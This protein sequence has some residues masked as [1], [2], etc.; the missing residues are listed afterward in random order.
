MSVRGTR[1]TVPAEVWGRC[2]GGHHGRVSAAGAK[3]WQLLLTEHKNKVLFEG[4][5]K[6]FLGNRVF[7]LGRQAG[8]VVFISTSVEDQEASGMGRLRPTPQSWSWFHCVSPCLQHTVLGASRCQKASWDGQSVQGGGP[9]SLQSPPAQT[10]HMSMLW[11]RWPLHK[12]M[13]TGH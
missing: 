9:S 11:T 1:L 8:V 12:G 4:K 2:T 5:W 13:P 3:C 6:H 10:I 7:P